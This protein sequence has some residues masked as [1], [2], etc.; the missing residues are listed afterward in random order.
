MKMYWLVPVVMFFVGAYTSEVLGSAY[1]FLLGVAFLIVC[2]VIEELQ[3]RR[4]VKR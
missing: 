4:L 1:V 2:M 3:E